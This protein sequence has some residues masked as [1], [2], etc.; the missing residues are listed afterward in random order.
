MLGYAPAM[1]LYAAADLIFATKI[2]STA[3]S[4]GV[5]TRPVRNTDMLQ[6]RLDRVDDGKPNN[7][8]TA[9]LLDLDLGD[10][11]LSLLDLARQ[12]TSERGQPLPVIAFGAHVAV[13]LLEAARQRGADA[14]MP[15][16][17]FTAQ[18][19]DL[20]QRLAGE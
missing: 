2:R 8:P 16:G 15:R 11:A 3:Q 9:L 14:V 1:I 12:H 6:A 7:A 19:P 13:D 20:L 17:A 18:L 10:T 4:L 5:I